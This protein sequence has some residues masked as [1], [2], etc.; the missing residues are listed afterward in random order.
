ME[1]LLETL[2]LDDLIEFDGERR[3]RKRLILTELIE[4]ELVCYEP[5]QGT[6]EHHHVGQDEI[7]YV[8]EGRGTM[9]VD[10]ENVPL[11]PKGL[12]LA[13]AGARHSVQCAGDSRL[14]IIFFKAPGRGKKSA[15]RPDAAPA[16]AGG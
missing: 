1:T 7:F 8:V 2:S 15:K 11:A 16:E 13:P 5:G 4:S 3:V 9:V 10:G 12:V 14:A 6:V